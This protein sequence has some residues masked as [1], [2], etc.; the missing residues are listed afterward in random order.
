MQH[1][2]LLILRHSRLSRKTRESVLAFFVFARLTHECRK[3]NNLIQHTR[4]GCSLGLERL[5]LV[6]I[7]SLQ[8]LGLDAPTSRFRLGLET[9]TS[10]SRLG[11]LVF[12]SRLHRTSKFKLRTI[13]IKFSTEILG[14]PNYISVENRH[15][16]LFL[17]YEMFNTIA[18]KT[19]MSWMWSKHGLHLNFC[20]G[21]N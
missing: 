4:Q 18:I 10:R 21:N 12:T 5:G 16:C 19:W 17:N 15:F 8:S 11:F 3:I 6:S 13:T 9:L 20:F 7:P 14:L 1:Y 2:V